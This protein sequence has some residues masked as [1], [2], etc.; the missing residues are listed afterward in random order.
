MQQIKQ[1]I[2]CQIWKY[3]C[4]FNAH[5]GW[6][7]HKK[8]PTTKKQK[9]TAKIDIKR[10]CVSKT[11]TMLF[12]FKLVKRRTQFSQLLIIHLKRTKTILYKYSFLPYLNNLWFP[13]GKKPVLGDHESYDVTALNQLD[14][15]F[16]IIEYCQ[17]L[18]YRKINS[19]T[20]FFGAEFVHSNK[21]V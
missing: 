7:K 12:R 15:L 11:T 14:P 20:I 6:D 21:Y 17:I 1:H 8:I 5:F 19:I 2:K 18:K 3:G 9:N 4:K 13:I 16:F 10:M